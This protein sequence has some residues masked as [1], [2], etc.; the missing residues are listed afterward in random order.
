MHTLHFRDFDEFAG[1]VGDVDSTMLMVNPTERAWTIHHT[2]MAGIHV[3]LGRMG[4]GNIAECQLRADG[5]LLYIPLSDRREYVISGT[6]LAEGGLAVLGPSCEFCVATKAA[7]DWASI[8]VPTPLIARDAQG[9]GPAWKS[10]ANEARVVRTSREIVS[11]QR[12]LVQRVVAASLGRPEIE[13]SPA[14]RAAMGELFDA[15][16]S[17]F[18]AAPTRE[19]RRI[20]RPLV[21][22]GQIIR[23][24]RDLLDQRQGKPVLVPDLAAAAGVSE[25]T[26]RTAFNEAFGVGPV[27]Y[28]Q[29][30]Q[31]HQVHRDLRISDR[32]ETSVADVLLRQ[33]IW[34]FGR[35]TGRYRQ[36]FGETPSATLYAKST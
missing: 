34:D 31:L 25:R 32:E 16:S 10:D 19:R 33:G 21:R 7:H 18:A 36:L 30:R 17:V 4:S 29:L 14:A 3:Q 9:S 11:R 13:S 28:L 24:I 35:F 27:R 26:L 6:D 20:G 1:S 22:R 15:A 5:Y 23:S 8:F 2:N 12:A